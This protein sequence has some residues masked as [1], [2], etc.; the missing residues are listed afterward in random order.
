MKHNKG[1]SS[2]ALILIIIVV[3]LIGAGL[4]FLP[5]IRQIITV[6]NLR[7]NP[8]IAK[9]GVLE[10][11][12]L[13]ALLDIC[14]TRQSCSEHY[15]PPPVQATW[16]SSNI[17]I[18]TVSYKNECPISVGGATCANIPDYLNATV[19]GV[20]A[21]TATIKAT[22]T[23]SSGNVLTATSL[24]TVTN[25]YIPTISTTLPT[26]Y[27]SEQENWP[28]VIQNSGVAYSCTPTSGTLDMP[29]NVQR[30]IGNRTYCITTIVDGTAG[31]IYNTFTY[32]T[33]SSNGSGTKTANFI[34]RYE[35][36]GVYDEPQH[37]QCRNAQSNFNLDA[38]VDSLI[39]Q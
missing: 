30:V 2:V 20:S 5:T 28:P 17:N 26:P 12:T 9:I 33:A 35:N 8:P 25:S 23:N 18:I 1:F 19:T 37:S 36:C 24:I 11:T 38:I 29:Q 27:I 13:F 16:T 4:Y 6:N 14:P 31:S 15:S 39:L 7:I 21:G 10:S 32:T 34:L 22:Y 3:A